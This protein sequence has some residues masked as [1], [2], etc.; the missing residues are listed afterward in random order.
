LQQPDWKQLVAPAMRRLLRAGS[1]ARFALRRP[2]P[3]RLNL[4]AGNQKVPGYFAIDVAG[5]VDLLLELAREDLPFESGSIEAVACIS[6]INYVSHQRAAELVAETFRV[7]RPGGVARFA[8]QDLRKLVDYYVRRDRGFFEQKNPDGS[9][10]FE[11]Q[12]YGDKFVAWFYGHRTAGGPC[13]YVYDYESLAALFH[14]AGFTTVEER[15]FGVSRLSDVAL[16]DNRP[17]QMF[18]LEAVK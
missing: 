16:L 11:G 1:R 17:E 3:L 9:E 12:T 15:P 5:D 18:F 7:L 10:R 4:G 13:R 14:G 2:K 8:V 6:A